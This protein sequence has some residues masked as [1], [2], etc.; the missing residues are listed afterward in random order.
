MYSNLILN[1]KRKVWWPT[2]K[3]PISG[4]NFF[5]VL[6]VAFVPIDLRWAYWNTSQSI[7]HKS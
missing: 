6:Q 3:V 4:I 2:K 1:K 5:N 7:Q